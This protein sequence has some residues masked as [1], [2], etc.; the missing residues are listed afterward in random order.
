[1]TSVND[2][3]DVNPD[4]L[5]R[6]LD[7]LRSQGAELR[8]QADG[9]RHR[10]ARVEAENRAKDEFLATLSH[11]LRTPL[12]AMLGWAQMLATEELD[13]L[14]FARAV[15]SIERNTKLQAQLIDELLDVSRIVT[16]KL[17]LDQRPLNVIPLVAA[18][19][20]GFRAQ[21][22]ERGLEL[23]LDL[24]PIRDVVLG[25]A[26]RIQ[27]VV[28]N[29]ITNAMKFTGRGGRISVSVAAEGETFVSVSVQDTGRGI[30]AELLPHVFER[31]RQGDSSTTKPNGG[32]GLGLAIARHVV[33]LHGGTIRAESRG[34]GAG[35]TFTFSLPSLPA[36]VRAP[37]PR[38]T[39]SFAG[40]GEDARRRAELSGISVL[41]VDDEPDARELVGLMLGQF[42]ASVAVASSVAEALE[43][44]A[45][46]RPDVIVSDIAMP[47]HDGYQLMRRVRALSAEHGGATPA[48]AVTAY[49]TRQD[50]E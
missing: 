13:A 41:V 5:L 48:I 50:R 17:R 42:G 2:L 11:E 7:A 10:L 3:D 44:L 23:V 9:L 38:R 34:E 43:Q 37:P 24:E 28:D 40:R 27:Q 26:R 29:L 6:E 32:L 35:A 16:G 49:A 4:L 45:R 20:D 21:A 8:A 47:S 19:V 36:D 12:N 31:F 14:A 30:R 39:S 33:E 15:Q 18:A 25:D 46:R 1:M 22:D